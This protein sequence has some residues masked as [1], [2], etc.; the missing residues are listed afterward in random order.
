MLLGCVR[1][2]L[3]ASLVDITTLLSVPEE[4]FVL[5]LVA[6]A[7]VAAW[8]NSETTKLVFAQ[9]LGSR[10]VAPQHKEIT[11]LVFCICALREFPYPL[12]RPP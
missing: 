10:S 12:F 5:T 3:P 6:D 8:P 1:S 7:L 11:D 9:K 4:Q 2:R